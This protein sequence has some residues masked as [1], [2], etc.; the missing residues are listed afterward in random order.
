VPQ[1][2]DDQCIQMCSRKVANV[3]GD[4]RKA[5][6]VGKRVGGGA[7]RKGTV[8]G[9]KGKKPLRLFYSWDVVRR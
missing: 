5:F 1:V 9:G 3:S 7:G 2:I 8:G 6:Q 4:L